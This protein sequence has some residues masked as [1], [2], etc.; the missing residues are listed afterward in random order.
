MEQ[1][2]SKYEAQSWDMPSCELRNGVYS[3]C[4]GC[5]AYSSCS[6]MDDFIDDMQALE[7]GP[8]SVDIAVDLV[9]LSLGMAI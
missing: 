8:N 1:I 9:V 7:S 4:P 3:T 6:T 2:K 5:P